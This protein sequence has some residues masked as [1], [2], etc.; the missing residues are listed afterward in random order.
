MDQID[1]L[2][3]VECLASLRT[4]PLFAD[5]DVTDLAHLAV[6]TSQRR[7]APGELIFSQGEGG[8]EMLVVVEGSATVS[9]VVEGERKVVATLAAGDFVG[10]L[11]LLTHDPRSADVHAGPD[12]LHG[13]VISAAT[14][15]AVVRERP[16]VGLTML[17]ALAE[18]LARTPLTRH[19]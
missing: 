16:R 17:G 15:E 13:L 5:L 12:G 18:R 9:L 2:G 3:E 4:V 6:V 8:N 19:G 10:E 1:T 7:Y 11:S 14:F